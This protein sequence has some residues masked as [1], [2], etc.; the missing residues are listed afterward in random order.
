[1]KQGIKLEKQVLQIVERLEC[2]T[3][4]LELGSTGSNNLLKLCKSRTQTAKVRKD[5]LKDYVNE[6]WECS[7]FFA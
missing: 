5:L 6:E 1:M 3:E 4:E 7:F 2:Y